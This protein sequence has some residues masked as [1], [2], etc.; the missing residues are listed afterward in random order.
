MSRGLL[1][2]NPNPNPRKYLV[3]LHSGEKMYKYGRDR[4]KHKRG[5]VRTAV[6]RLGPEPS[7]N[8]KHVVLTVSEGLKPRHTQREGVDPVGKGHSS[9]SYAPP[10][11]ASIFPAVA[12]LSI[13]SDSIL[14]HL[15]GPLHPR[16]GRLTS[17]GND[18]NGIRVVLR[19]GFIRRGSDGHELP[20]E[21]LEF[22][23]THFHRHFLTHH[24]TDRSVGRYPRRG[25]I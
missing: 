7:Q 23:R 2:L 1:V 24:R 12:L 22:P 21:R 16:L 17:P 15:L 11:R 14:Q 13:V 8:G 4:R 25:D 20:R 18:L 3:K 9:P 10:T 19:F 6:P 5:E